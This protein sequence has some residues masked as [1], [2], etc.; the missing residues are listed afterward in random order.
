MNFLV[1]K[2]T[3]YKK[4]SFEWHIKRCELMCRC[5]NNSCL[6]CKTKFYFIEL[7]EEFK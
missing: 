4:Y 2:P 3:K 7:K 6:Y 5:I 1:K